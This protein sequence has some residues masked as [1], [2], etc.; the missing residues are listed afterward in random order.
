MALANN[1]PVRSILPD[2]ED[3]LVSYL[4]EDRLCFVVAIDNQGVPAVQARAAQA[5]I[6]AVVLGAVGV[7]TQ[8]RLHDHLGDR[9]FAADFG[10]LV[11]EAEGVVG[12]IVQSA[13]R[14]RATPRPT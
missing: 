2:G 3:F 5:G 12:A 10:T 7:T 4:G 14:P 1:L 11:A 13:S 8:V 9:S 6:E